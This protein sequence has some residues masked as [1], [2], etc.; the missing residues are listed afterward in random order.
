M[1]HLN[2]ISIQ[3]GKCQLLK[4][5]IH[6]IFQH[7][8]NHFITPSQKAAFSYLEIHHFLGLRV[9]CIY[10]YMGGS[11]NRPHLLLKTPKPEI[12]YHFHLHSVSENQSHGNTQ[13]RGKLRIQFLPGQLPSTDNSTIGKRNINSV[14]PLAISTI[15]SLMKTW[16][17][18]LFPTQ[19]MLPKFLQINYF[20][21]TILLPI[22][23]SWHQILP[24]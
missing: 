3:L 10:P 14:W 18:C 19:N 13:I 9:L 8:K 21:H 20:E 15:V 5:Q 4:P 17:T 2:R 22:I 1:K 7:N 12:I 23:F 24:R 11:T 6:Q 16:I